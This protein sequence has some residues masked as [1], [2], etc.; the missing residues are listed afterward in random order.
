MSDS[1]GETGELVVKAAVSQFGSGQVDIRHIPFLT[2][3]REVEDAL[4]EVS[5]CGG[6]VIYTL[7]RPDLKEVLVGKAAALDLTCI[8]IMGPILDVIAAV[9]GKA[10]RLEPGL[11]RRMDEAYF[12]KVEAVEF[13]VK[14]DDGKQPW[15]LAKADLVIIGVSRTSKTPLCMYLAYKGIKAANVP[16][17]PE[18]APPETLFEVP[19]ARIVG[20]TIHP[21][22]LYAVRRERLKTLGLAECVNYASQER[23]EQELAYAQSVFRRVGCPVV[24]VTNRAVEETAAKILEYYRKGVGK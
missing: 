9:T 1:V 22:L 2:S 10:P 23:I 21:P 19:P 18:V 3:A 24:D 20:L 17:V 5:A 12:N 15:G 8:D 11:L 13:A 6:A 7:V 14:Y 16:L 4:L